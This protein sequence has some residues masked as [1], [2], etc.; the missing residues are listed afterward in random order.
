MADISAYRFQFNRV[1]HV[2]VVADMEPKFDLTRAVED[3]LKVGTPVK[4]DPQ[5]LATLLNRH[6]EVM[7][8]RLPWLEGH[9]H[10]GRRFPL[11]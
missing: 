6:R 3:A 11:P 2:A 7:R 8:Q 9:Y 10:P 4:L 5:L 1:W